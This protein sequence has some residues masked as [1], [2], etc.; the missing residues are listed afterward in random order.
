MNRI[1]DEEF[2]VESSD[3]DYQAEESSS[4]NSH[5]IT[6]EEVQEK[7]L[8]GDFDEYMLPPKLNKKKPPSKPKPKSPKKKAPP[9]SS[10]PKRAKAEEASALPAGRSQRKRS[11]PARFRD[12]S[13][14]EWEKLED[15]DKLEKRQKRNEEA[16]QPKREDS[17]DSGMALLKKESERKVFV[18]E[19]GNEFKI[20]G[21]RLRGTGGH[22]IPNVPNTKETRALLAKGTDVVEKMVLFR[23]C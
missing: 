6:D 21:P 20:K 1:L 23:V 7:D 3:S 19:D 11:K 10:S 8:M 15:F 13:E 9:K 14:E 4:S 17:D 5:I 16:S 12:E 18:D 2:G 22:V